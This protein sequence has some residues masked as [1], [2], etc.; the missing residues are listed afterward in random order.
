[1]Y[2]F[3]F[4]DLCETVRVSGAW[5]RLF[6]SLLAL[7]GVVAGDVRHAAAEGRWCAPELAALGEGTCFFGPQLQKAGSPR[8]LVI[9]MH[10]LVGE[11][12]S[13]QWEQ[14]RLMV[15]T[16]EAYGLSALMPR[17]RLG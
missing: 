12:S 10:G 16:A 1:M 3:C 6:W 14:Q 15:R 13:W 8:V 7:V 9:F 11:G 17:G 5:A 4:T 2:G